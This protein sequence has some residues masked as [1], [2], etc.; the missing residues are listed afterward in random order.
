MRI[1]PT[2][3]KPTR[4]LLGHAIRGELEA[5]GQ[6]VYA[7][8]DERYL[9]CINLCIAIAG[10]LGIDIAERWPSDADLREIARHAAETT[11]KF[12]LN[13]SDVFDYLSRIVFGAEK[14]DQVFPDITVSTTLP[15]LATAS[16]LVSFRPKNLRDKHWWDYL[17]VIEG[18]SEQATTLDPAVLPA[19]TYRVRSAQ[20]RKP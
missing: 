6:Q 9:E 18:A 20:I 8:G 19:F 3:E 14:L 1:D 15:I 10:Y 2:I 4:D 11:T 17:D 13:A 12:D 7:I 16:I 5:M